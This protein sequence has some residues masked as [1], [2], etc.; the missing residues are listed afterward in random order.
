MK[1]LCPHH[2]PKLAVNFFRVCGMGALPTIALGFDKSR[3]DPLRLL[4]IQLR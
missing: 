2:T 3:V 1:N 4:Q